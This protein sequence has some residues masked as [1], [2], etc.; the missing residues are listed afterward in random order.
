[1]ATAF[2]GN[3]EFSKYGDSIIRWGS[4]LSQINEIHKTT[5]LILT[6]GMHET[7]KQSLPSARHSLLIKVRQAL[8]SVYRDSFV[9]V[10]SVSKD[11]ELLSVDVTL[12]KA[13]HRN[14]QRRT[15]HF[16]FK[17]CVILYYTIH[18]TQYSGVSILTLRWLMSYIYGAPILDVSRSHKTTQHSR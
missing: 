6:H 4:V 7:S 9:N 5:A 13:S 8:R 2:R 16:C 18:I 15:S 1:M 11:S 10:L 12:G 14:Y 17:L 3:V